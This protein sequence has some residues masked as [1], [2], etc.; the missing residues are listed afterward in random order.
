MK[1][2]IIKTDE[3]AEVNES[4]GARLIEQGKAVPYKEAPRVEKAKVAKA[5]VSIEAEKG[6]E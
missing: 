5:T 1:V 6:D 3:L 4:Y 2:L